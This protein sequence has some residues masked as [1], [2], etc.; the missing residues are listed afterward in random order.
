L[1]S[2]GAFEVKVSSTDDN[3]TSGS[4]NISSSGIK[5]T[6]AKGTSEMDGANYKVVNLSK[7]PTVLVESGASGKGGFNKTVNV[8]YTGAKDYIDNYKKGATAGETKV[9]TTTVTYTIAAK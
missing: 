2:T 8:D 4:D 5:L 7:T 6:A 9:Y 1:Y 3:L